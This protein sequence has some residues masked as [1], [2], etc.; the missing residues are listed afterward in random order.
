MRSLK[1][2]AVE[3]KIN[4]NLRFFAQNVLSESENRGRGLYAVNS[5]NL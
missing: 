4:S 3:E 5:I 1:Q 2:E